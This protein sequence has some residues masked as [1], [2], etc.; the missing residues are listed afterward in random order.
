[1]WHVIFSD[2]LQI[3]A[4][5]VDALARFCLGSSILKLI[6]SKIFD[7]FYIRSV[8]FIIASYVLYESPV[9]FLLIYEALVFYGMPVIR[10]V[11][12]F[13]LH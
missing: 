4:I 9:L 1:M 12:L 11:L 13:E 3:F 6:S 10:K 2:L 8:S 7:Q 5:F